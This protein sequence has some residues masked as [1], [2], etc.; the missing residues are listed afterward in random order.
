[1]WYH[2]CSRQLCALIFCR[3]HFS[4]HDVHASQKIRRVTDIK[5]LTSRHVLS[6]LSRSKYKLI[7]A[8]SVLKLIKNS[9][10]STKQLS[11]NVTYVSWRW[12]PQLSPE[13]TANCAHPV[14]PHHVTPANQPHLQPR[15][16]HHGLRERQP[17]PAGIGARQN[18]KPRAEQ[19]QHH[20]SARVLRRCCHVAPRPSSIAYVPVLPPRVGPTTTEVAGAPP[21][22]E[23]CAPVLSRS[24]V[25]RVLPSLPLQIR[26]VARHVR[27]TRGVPVAS[28]ASRQLLCEAR[29][30]D[31]AEFAAFP[32][33]SPART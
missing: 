28:G 32:A 26:S 8:P 30:R 25:E 5:L 31:A 10:F 6:I 12:F 14:S 17:L 11:L 23:R 9:L 15:L 21:R 29:H 4:L 19:A 7:T 20:T 2:S 16:V 22:A 18:Q 24:T 1:M 13:V 3:V 27:S 33:P